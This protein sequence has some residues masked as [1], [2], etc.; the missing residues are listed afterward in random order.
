MKEL[1]DYVVIGGG[2]VR[3]LK[4]LPPHCR[5]GSNDNAFTG[6]FRLWQKGSPVS[7]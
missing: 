7:R 3:E 1:Y 2:N 5:A 4:A 6:G